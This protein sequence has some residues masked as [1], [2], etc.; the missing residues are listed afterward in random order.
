MV[1]VCTRIAVVRLVWLVIEQQWSRP[2]GGHTQRCN[3]VQTIN[4]TLKVTT[5]TA[6]ECLTVSLL[7]CAR[8]RVVGLIAITEA[9]RHNQIDSIC[10]CKA[11]THCRVLATR[12]NGI[13]VLKALIALLKY[14]VVCTCSSVACNS[15]IGKDIVRAIGLMSS[16]NLY[17]ITALNSYAILR[18]VLSTDKQLQWGLH[19]GPPAKRLNTNN[20]I[21]SICHALWVK[22][23][24]L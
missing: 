4:H 21:C 20:L 2:N 7:S 18:D 10:S 9:V 15:H 24:A 6:K 12:S 8:C 22:C 17:P 5:V 16:C 11:L 23:C 19:I 1:V 13:R 3:I 14:Q